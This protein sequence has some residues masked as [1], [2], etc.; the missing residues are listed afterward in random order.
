MN[1]QILG[2]MVHRAALHNVTEMGHL[3]AT[4]VLRRAAGI[5]VQVSSIDLPA[6]RRLSLFSLEFRDA[7]VVLKI[8]TEYRDASR[9]L[10][11]DCSLNSAIFPAS[12]NQGSVSTE[13]G[14]DT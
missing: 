7:F 1:V 3:V 8:H 2:S 12:G 13:C 9:L 4:W 10:F 5:P 14:S 11:G 6:F